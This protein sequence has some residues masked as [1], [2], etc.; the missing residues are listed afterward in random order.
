VNK[1]LTLL[2]IF[3]LAFNIAFVGIWVHSR[4]QAAKP[5]EGRPGAP[6]GELG[7]NP[8]QQQRLR[9]RWQAVRSEAARLRQE[10]AGAREELLELIV[11]EEPDQEAILATEERL[12]GLQHRMRELAVSQMLETRRI[13]EPPQRREWIRLLKARGARPRPA[14]WR[15]GPPAPPGA[16]GPATEGPGGAPLTPERMEEF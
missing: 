10:A 12:A 1:G 15:H 16:A 13:L 2:L 4:S 14:L 6:W 3:S 8:A 9:G 11:A 7:L 5:P